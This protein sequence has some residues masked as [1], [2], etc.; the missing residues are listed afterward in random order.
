MKERGGEGAGREEWIFMTNATG[1]CLNRN[2][3]EEEKP[4]QFLVHVLLITSEEG[5]KTQVN[6]NFRG[7]QSTC[8]AQP[9]EA[10]VAFLTGTFHTLVT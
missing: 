5:K 10:L 9:M 2:P 4:S 7:R 1:A 6:I 3:G 8:R